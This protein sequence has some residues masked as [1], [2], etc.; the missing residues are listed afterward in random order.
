MKKIIVEIN[1]NIK[2][3][4]SFEVKLLSPLKLIVLILKKPKYVNLNIKINY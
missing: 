4:K 1:K 2:G 3:K